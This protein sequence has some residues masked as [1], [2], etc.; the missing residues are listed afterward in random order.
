MDNL[1]VG[2]A[3]QVIQDLNGFS[4]SIVYGGIFRRRVQEVSLPRDCEAESV[5]SPTDSIAGNYA[6]KKRTAPGNEDNEPVVFSSG[7]IGT[8]LT[9]SGRKVSCESDSGESSAG[10]SR[11]TLAMSQE[12]HGYSYRTWHQRL[13][14]R[15][16]L[17][18]APPP[19]PVEP[20]KIAI[21]ASTF[22]MGEKDVSERELV[23]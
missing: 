7:R 5:S 3:M 19:V 8:S 9:Q 12:D 23:S 2:L 6:V 4:N 10:K 14:K 16:S 18:H 21:F 20:K 1:D 15:F 11:K 22:N 17:H 13:Q